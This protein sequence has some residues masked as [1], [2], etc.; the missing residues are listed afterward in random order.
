[1][2]DKSEAAVSAEQWMREA[3]EEIRQLCIQQAGI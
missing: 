3:A 2:T 1:M